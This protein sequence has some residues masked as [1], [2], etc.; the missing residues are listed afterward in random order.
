MA[1]TTIVRPPQLT[2]ELRLAAANRIASEKAYDVPALCRR[3]GLADGTE[4]DAFRSKFRYAS[5]RLL[6]LSGDSLLALANTLATEGSTYELD[7]AKAKFAEYGAPT[8]VT[9]LTRR[10]LIK[11]FEGYPLTTE[12]DE[13][14]LLRRV[15]PLAEMP[16]VDPDYIGTRTLDDDVWQHTVNNDDW[17]YTRLFEVLGL[18][19]CSRERLFRFLGAVTHPLMQNPE[20]QVVLVADLNDVLRHDRY[21]LRQV[22][23]LSGTPIFEVLSLAAGSPADAGISAALEAFDPDSIHARWTAALER[24]DTAPAGAITLARTLLEDVCKWILTE[25]DVAFEDGAELPVL[26]RLLSKQLKLAPDD[27][28]EPVFK[29]LLGSCQNIVESLGSLRNKLGD[30]H[31][32]GPKRARPLPRHAQLAVNLSG[33]MATFLVE[34][35]QVRRAADLAELTP[36]G[37]VDSRPIREHGEA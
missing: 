7:E 9:E 26:Y 20:R 36:L 13:I 12:L 5:M 18:F 24:R 32:P 10:R 25:A 21:E 28:T 16:P 4:E 33:T 31:S 30:A 19:D 34:T 22:G 2:R 37:R 3:L 17:S 6:E 14:D 1:Q 8:V 11:C 27:H 15:W 35:W 29:A 23:K